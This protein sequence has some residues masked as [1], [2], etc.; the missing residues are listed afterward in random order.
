MRPLTK[1]QIRAPKRQTEPL[2]LAEY[3]APLLLAKPSA[4]L[5]VKLRE[6]KATFQSAE[7]IAE[8]VSDMLVDETGARMFTPAEVPTFLEGISAE[9]FTSLVT[10]CSEMYAGKAGGQGN[11]QPAPSA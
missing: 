1:E 3:S 7:T 5:A 9:S 10:K 8:M 11:S 4:L 6:S 2:T